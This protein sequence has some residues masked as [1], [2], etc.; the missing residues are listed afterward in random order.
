MNK[1]KY[2]GRGTGLNPPNRF[3]KLHIEETE[4]ITDETD[5]WDEQERKLETIFYKDYSKSVIAKNNSPDIYFDY[6]FNPYRGCEH[7]CVYCYARPTHEFLGFSSGIDF[8]SKI[9]VK[10]DAAKL[11]KQTFEKKN[12]KPKLIMFSGD[13]DCYQPVERKLGITRSALEVCLEYY[14]PV[15]VITKSSLVLR[16][17]DI[18]RQ[19][20]ELKIVTVTLSVTTLNKELASKMEPRASTPERRLMT[21]EKLSENGIPT[22]VNAAPIIPGLNDEEIPEILKQTS[23]CGAVFAG[24][25]LLRLPYSLKDLF[26]DWLEREFPDRKE[27]ILNKIMEM[28]GGKLN[29]PEFG[30][31]FSGEGKQVETIRKLFKL[32]CRKYG[33]N[34]KEIEITTRHFRRKSGPQLELF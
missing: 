10:E 20:A 13:T 32:S 29:E 4:D 6:S 2:P 34:N 1:I 19:M 22:G 16:D 12:Y 5:Y 9:M 24:F 28:R 15:S 8:E 26:I 11:L 25:T 17:I 33:L 27:K 14:N 30:K 31:R 3:E 18:L 23:E 7:G 21:I